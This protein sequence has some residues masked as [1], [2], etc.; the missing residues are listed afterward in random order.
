M[1][2]INK[3]LLQGWVE[4]APS[5]RYFS[6]TLV[7][8]DFSLRTEEIVMGKDGERTLTLWHKIIAWGEVAKTI[9]QHIHQGDEVRVH[10]SLRY[11]READRSGISKL[12]TEIEVTT[13]DLIA[14]RA[15]EPKSSPLEVVENEN[16]IDELPWLDYAPSENEDPMA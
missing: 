16:S 10:G 1:P 8:T 9:E 5:I 3:V 12:I 14:H 15:D 4:Q 7:R 2:S 6:Y 13:V 11:H